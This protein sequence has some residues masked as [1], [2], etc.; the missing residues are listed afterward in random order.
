MKDKIR[1]LIIKY[2][3]YIE[4]MKWHL[5]NNSTNPEIREVCEARINDYITTV[6]DLKK[7]I[8]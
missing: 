5:E 4:N 3:K 1:F 7:V 6:D 2:E 8:K